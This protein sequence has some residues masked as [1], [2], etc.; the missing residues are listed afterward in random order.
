MKSYPIAEEIIT[1]IN[2]II[3]KINDTI[4]TPTIVI[5]TSDGNNTFIRL[6]AHNEIFKYII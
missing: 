1:D 3:A 2:F 5:F 4:K 6:V